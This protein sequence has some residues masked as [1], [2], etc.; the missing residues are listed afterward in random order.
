[1]A[2]R[3]RID[4]ADEKKAIEA[5]V[6]YLLCFTTIGATGV[7]LIYE[8]KYST[9][10]QSNQAWISNYQPRERRCAW[11]ELWSRRLTLKNMNEGS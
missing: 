7:G 10:N 1:M 5:T 8:H 11:M 4:I 3:M 2:Q 6:H 9:R